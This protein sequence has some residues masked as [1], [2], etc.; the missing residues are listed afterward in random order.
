MR[1]CEQASVC[2]LRGSLFLSAS[3]CFCVFD[4]LCYCLVYF[5]FR[6]VP[7]TV[8]AVACVRAVVVACSARWMV[9]RV[10]EWAQ[11]VDWLR[12]CVKESRP[13]AMYMPFT[14]SLCCLLHADE[15]V[16]RVYNVHMSRIPCSQCGRSLAASLSCSSSQ[17]NSK[18]MEKGKCVITE[19]QARSNNAAHIR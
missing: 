1:A 7:F 6:S 4:S 8:C 9:K 12:E 13:C 11:Q 5:P 10:S 19:N 3:E 15:C 2:M 17:Q 16:Q 18:T 14:Y